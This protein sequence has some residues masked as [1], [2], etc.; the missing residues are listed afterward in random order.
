[1]PAGAFVSFD[2]MDDAGTGRLLKYA[3]VGRDDELA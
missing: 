1:V 3:T 2:G